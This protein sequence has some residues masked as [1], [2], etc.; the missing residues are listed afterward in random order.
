MARAH[1]TRGVWV[2][3]L[4]VAATSG[5]PGGEVI[6]PPDA[7]DFDA[8]GLDAPRPPMDGGD[9]G[10]AACTVDD[11]CTPSTD[12]CAPRR[13][14][15]GACVPEPVAC[16]DGDPC[17]R[18]ACDPA[19][20]TCSAPRE[21]DGTACGGSSVCC[22]GAC[23]D[24]ETDAANCGGCG[25]VCGANAGCSGG[26]CECDLGFDD[27]DGAPGCES[28]SATD[29][30][31]CGLCGAVCSGAT[32]SCLGGTC[33]ACTGASDCVE[34]GL[35]CTAPP[36]CDAG[37][38]R[39]A[40]VAG[41]CLVG[42]G[43]YA[44]G[45][46]D[47]ANGCM[48]CEPAASVTAFSPR[49]GAS[50]DDGIFCTDADACD[51]TGT[52]AG[53]SRAC[54]DGLACTA[55][56][57]NEGM[58]RC[59]HTARAGFCAIDGLCLRS[60]E[61]N[62]TNPVC[63]MCNPATPGMWTPV[64]G[65]PCEDG[66]YCTVADTCSAAGTC[67]G[68]PRDCTDTQACTADACDE[69]ADVCTHVLA[70][71]CMIGGACF[72][73]GAANPADPCFECDPARGATTWSPRPGASCDDG[74]FCTGVDECDATGVCV[75]TPRACDDALS[76]TTDSCDE[77]ADACVAA[78]TSD[79]CV[80]GGTCYANG[81]IDPGNPCRACI[82]TTSRSSWSPRTGVACDDGL[83]CTEVD[84]C[85]ATGACTGTARGC[86]DGNDCTADTCNET[87]NACESTL[88]GGSCVIDG[89][90]RPA[91]GLNPANACQECRPA[92]STSA[93]SV[94]TGASCDDGLFCTVSDQCTAAAACVGSTNTC[95]DGV[96]CTSD[97]CNEAADRC[98]NPVQA[99]FCLVDG[100]CRTSG[101][102]D[103]S[104]ACAWC[105]PVASQTAWT[106]RTGTRCVD[107]STAGCGACT[108]SATCATSTTCSD[109]LPCT[110]DACDDATGTCSAPPNP[111]SCA[112][113]GA[114]YAAGTVDPANPCR[115]CDPASSPTGW[116]A[117]TG[118]R[119][120]DGTTSGCGVCNTSGLCAT[121]STCT[122][123]LGCT[124]DTCD[125]A[126]GSCSYPVG[127]GSCLIAG[128]CYADMSVNV[129]N[130]CLWCNAAA[131]PNGWSPR[132]GARCN[133][134][135]TAG[136]G[137]CSGAAVCVT[138]TTC[139]DG[140]ACTVDACDD[141][142]GSCSAPISAGT[143][144]IDGA[145]RGSGDVNPTNPCQSC[146]P[147]ISQ[148]AWT[149]RTGVRCSD[150]AVASCGRCT[151]AAACALDTT[152]SD[153]LACTV[154]TCDDATGACSYPPST[155]NCMIGGACHPNGAT[156]GECQYCDSALSPTAWTNR[157]ITTNC[158]D[159]T[160]AGCG[161][162]NAT[163][164]CATASTC[165][166]TPS[167]TLDT[168]DDSNGS[169]S[170]PIAAGSCL[171][172]GACYAHGASNGPCQVCD[173]TAN[174]T[175][176][177]SRPATTR[178]DDGMAVTC[179]FCGA[180][181]SAGTCV[182]GPSC[183]DGLTCTTDSCNDG[184]GA[185]TNSVNPGTCRI[186]TP[187]ACYLNGDANGACEYCDAGA[188]PTGWTPR[189]TS[190]FCNDGAAVTCGRCNGAGSC[191]PG[192][193]CAESPDLTCTTDTCNDA[194]SMCTNALNAGSCLI[195][196]ACYASGAAN[197]GIPCQVCNPSGAGGSTGWTPNTGAACND[198]STTTCNDT[199]ND[200]GM[201][202]GVALIN[203]F[204]DADGDGFG[205]GAMPAMY[206]P[207]T[208]NRAPTGT[209]CR[210]TMPLVRPNQTTFFGTPQYYCPSG[211][212][213]G[214]AGGC[215]PPRCMGSAVAC[216]TT[217]CATAPLATAFWDYNCSGTDELETVPMSNCG[218]ACA[219]GWSGTAPAA[220]CGA[221][222]TYRA[223][224]GDCAV[225]T[226][227]G[228]MS[229]NRGCR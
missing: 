44:A 31:N 67:T 68:L 174:P 121:G 83:F 156:N 161:R 65:V 130:A 39:Y 6:P 224:S 178:C 28:S 145:C 73:A 43:C 13:C 17:T 92:T 133:D 60:G 81:T 124:T 72:A 9:G 207:G 82:A 1:R 189:P 38:C 32:P 158:D 110:A 164:V 193:S 63:Q 11:D 195:A 136:C 180:G 131:N 228:V 215:D 85:D 90:C 47:P 29:P 128:A 167:C 52:C 212:L 64:E 27:C 190:T 19:T 114:C 37:V 209:D 210:D 214:S 129:G 143:C 45:D 51:A 162:C 125:D 57:C 152:C 106:A 33:A 10:G 169:C 80:I 7:P 20:G 227:L 50:C 58:A 199:C 220:T 179:G 100:V 153:G 137:T 4:A 79:S 111:G 112:I 94:R 55:D 140:L 135:T 186:G 101:T 184:T 126:T 122:D 194:T 59:V 54:D 48:A 95:G 155:G 118:A 176:W 77:A 196:G 42:G 160:L 127:G 205:N 8:A 15:A 188:N 141:A 49:V 218:C 115:L 98:D 105:E 191:A 182:A 170:Y 78:P 159:G 192:P 134:G 61:P 204:V 123:G 149:A 213:C 206:C 113:G 148:T 187:G 144:A 203:G 177:T 93:W 132:T 154:D 138:D 217:L 16:D 172:A 142:T 147:A 18:D 146:Q 12:L 200:S 71:G 22:A 219:S 3:W 183:S 173:A 104:N 163:G 21:P 117:R 56:S 201:C 222:Y 107:G 87:T 62:P 225:C 53:T 185:C 70:S 221:A 157:P 166:D 46:R 96:A 89:V 175:G 102:V 34:D 116:T 223:C 151:A 69:A 103:P 30:D 75:G 120:S 150:G 211:F 165:S 41:S 88:A 168:C 66:S 74:L 36:T 181:A 23:L 197:P 35:A 84:S 208:P 26:S 109:G 14:D 40:V 5:C 99:G 229:R 86:S 108:V 216:G 25:I 202:V 226:L 119:C 97:A 91:G 139:S 198:G 76:C 171:I 2:L 24:T